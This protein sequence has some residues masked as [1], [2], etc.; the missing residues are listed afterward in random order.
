MSASVLGARS[1]PRGEVNKLDAAAIDT[2]R[3]ARAAGPGHEK[4]LN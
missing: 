4:L 2:G 1:A 3:G